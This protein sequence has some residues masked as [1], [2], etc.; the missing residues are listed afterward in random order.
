MSNESEL[1]KE[2]EDII[3]EI[4]SEIVT[5]ELK[6]EEILQGNIEFVQKL[7]ENTTVGKDFNTIPE[8]LNKTLRTIEIEKFEENPYLNKIGTR[9][10]KDINHSHWEPPKRVR[11]NKKNG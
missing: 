8:I 4:V 9:S 2:L 5:S 3:D 6:D 10:Q 11:K 7:V 1:N